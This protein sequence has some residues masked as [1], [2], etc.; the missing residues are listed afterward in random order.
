VCKLTEISDEL[1]GIV[2]NQTPFLDSLLDGREIRICEDHVCSKFRNIRSAAHR[3]SDICLLQCRSVIDTI[4]SLS[5][6]INDRSEPRKRAAHHS[7]NQ[8]QGLKE[9]DQLTLVAWFSTAKYARDGDRLDLV[10]VT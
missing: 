3:D 6:R 5:N 2:V 1:S 10:F 8:A 9:I 4:T 7:H